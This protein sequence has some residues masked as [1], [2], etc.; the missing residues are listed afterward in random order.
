MTTSGPTHFER[1]AES[2]DTFA[3]SETPQMACEHYVAA[4]DRSDRCRNLGGYAHERERGIRDDA[5]A[6]TGSH[7]G[8]YGFGNGQSAEYRLGQHASV[9]YSFANF[10]RLQQ[11]SQEGPS[12]GQTRSE[13][14]R[15]AAQ[16]SSRGARTNPS[17]GGSAVANG[18]RRA[19]QYNGSAADQRGAGG[20]RPGVAGRRRN[21][22]IERR[23]SAGRST[24]RAADT[25]TRSIAALA[26]LYRAKPV[27]FGS[28]ERCR[29]ANGRPVRAGGAGASPRTSDGKRQSGA[30]EFD[31][32]AS[33][34]VA[35]RR[36]AR[37]RSGCASRRASRSGAS[38]ARRTEFAAHDHY[39]AGRRNGYR[40]R[41]FGGQHRRG[42]L[43][44][45]DA[46]Q[47]RARS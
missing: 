45:A 28:L 5:G 39:L 43:S 19:G 14:V 34:G 17:A 35:G 23:K 11:Q 10:C 38:S 12:V 21:G 47:H 6:S 27:R 40:A 33:D 3:V 7:A 44:I 25:L 22:A 9:R 32:D 18:E 29:G 20:Q 24:T 42:E 36:I 31:A 16:S 46:L 15:G 26:R 41:R 1:T 37:C 13:P 4:A 8:G 2:R 30:S